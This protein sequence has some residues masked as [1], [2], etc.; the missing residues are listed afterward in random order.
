MA[1]LAVKITDDMSAAQVTEVRKPLRRAVIASVGKAQA[2]KKQAPP[3]AEQIAL[4]KQTIRAEV[5]DLDS[6]AKQ[7]WQGTVA[8]AIAEASPEQIAVL[9]ALKAKRDERKAAEMAMAAIKAEEDAIVAPL[10]EWLRANGKTMIRAAGVGRFCREQKA[11]GV[12]LREP[13]E[14]FTLRS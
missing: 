11:A 6:R 7:A 1:G 4:A 8:E 2:R 5:E 9:A 14:S 13:S 3:T 12:S 10:K